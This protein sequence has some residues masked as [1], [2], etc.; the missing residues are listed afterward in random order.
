[1]GNHELE[2]KMKNLKV[3]VY[4]FGIVL[5]VCIGNGSTEISAQSSVGGVTRGLNRKMVMGFSQ[6]G[7][8]SA[9][10]TAN[11]NSVQAAAE[12][13]NVELK[14]SDAQQRQ[15]NQIQAIRTF[16]RQKVDI[17][18]FTPVV[19]T[20]WEAV[21]QEAKAAKIPVICVDLTI[22]QGTE[23]DLFTCYVGS[24]FKLEGQLA[25]EW[26]VNYMKEKGRDNK[27]TINIVELQGMASSTMVTDRMT[28][29][30]SY[31][32]KYPKYQIIKTLSGDFSRSKS[33][34][35]MEAFLKSDGG[36]IDAL[37]VHSDDMAIGAIHAIEEY[38]KK[39]GEDI[40]IVSIN[41]EKSAFEAI[42]AGKL[43]ATVE[44]S[45]AIGPQ[46]MDTAVKILTGQH[47]PKWV[48][49]NEGVF[50]QTNAAAAYPSRQY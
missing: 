27:G 39:P 43:N 28:G 48:V 45:P 22:A 47:V 15:E 11:T 26:L 35:I 38:G 37:Y 17:I 33:K 13:W 2:G 42:M 16:I 6:I 44:C 3:L 18:A 41:G 20:G 9:W 46:I 50:D 7:A 34:E 25:A 32:A 36:I 19:K 49:S 12:E 21:L 29:F 8:E 14:F 23:S 31:I 4:V 5:F 24:D 10:R 30:R 1:M 40:I